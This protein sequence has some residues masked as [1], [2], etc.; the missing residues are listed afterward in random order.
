MCISS[1]RTYERWT[2]DDGRQ[3]I[4]VTLDGKKRAELEATARDLLGGGL[5][6]DW[7]RDVRTEYCLS[8]YVD[9]SDAKVT[10]FRLDV[11]VPGPVV[12]VEGEGQPIPNHD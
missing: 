5:S 12:P 1:N 4:L 2:W 8:L 6:I 9:V 3:V 10:R 11:P 7:G